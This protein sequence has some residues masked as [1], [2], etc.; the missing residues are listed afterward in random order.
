MVIILDYS[1]GFNVIKQKFLR[2][3]IGGPKSEKNRQQKSVVWVMKITGQRIL[4]RRYKCKEM[5]SSFRDSSRNH[6]C[7]QDSISLLDS[8]HIPDLFKCE[9]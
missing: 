9:N 2:R 7:I 1:K 3:E 6:A 4:S 8:L 5:N